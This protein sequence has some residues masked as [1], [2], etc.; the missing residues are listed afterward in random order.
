MLLRRTLIAVPV[1][2]A[3]SGGSHATPMNVEAA[4]I[5]GVSLQTVP[6]LTW[7][8]TDADGVHVDVRDRRWPG[9]MR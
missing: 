2:L 4:G 6:P 1:L 9:Y 7:I 8:K 3:L 5:Q